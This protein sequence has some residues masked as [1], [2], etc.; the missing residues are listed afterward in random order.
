MILSMLR[1]LLVSV[2][3]VACGSK[4]QSQ[5][6]SAAQGQPEEQSSVVNQQST[7][8][9]CSK[10]SGPQD[11]FFDAVELRKPE[12][13]VDDQALACPDGT[14]TVTRLIGVGSSDIANVTEL[15]CQREGGTRHGPYQAWFGKNLH[16]EGEYDEGLYEGLWIFRGFGTD[17][18]K[19]YYSQGS[20]HGEWESR[21]TDAQIAWRGSFRCGVKVGTWTHW[22]QSGTSR[23]QEY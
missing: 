20:Q 6:P 5:T 7:A 9:P 4:S 22:D 16:T 3:L 21:H 12:P 2:L 17:S 8:P 10:V 15:F 18:R 1:S 11:P 23:P 13:V 19:G 14:T